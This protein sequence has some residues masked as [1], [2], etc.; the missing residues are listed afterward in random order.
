MNILLTVLIGLNGFILVVWL[1]RLVLLSVVSRILAPLHGTMYPAAA[2]NLPSVSMIVAA[3]DE[4]HNIEACI[5]SLERQTYPTLQIIAVNDRSTDGTREM[6]DRLAKECPRLTVRHVAQLREGWFGKN[7]AMREGVALAKGDWLCF[8]DADCIQLSPRSLE[9]AMRYALEKE[10]DFLSVLPSHEVH[11][12]WERVVQPACSA[13]MILWFSPLVVNNPRRKTAYANGAF[14][15][16]KRSCYEAMGGHEAVKNE[17]NEDMHMARIA[18]DIGRRLIVVN[19]RDLYTV[20]M[21]GTLSQIW[22]GWTRIFCGSFVTPRRLWAAVIVLATFS[23]APWLMLLFAV[24]MDGL[25]PE[26]WDIESLKYGAM[27]SCAAQLVTMGVFYALSR[28]GFLYGL[29][30]PI[31]AFLSMGTLLNAIRCASGRGDIRWR[32]TTYRD[33]AIAPEIGVV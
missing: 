10:T 12:F 1:M 24:L 13:I 16:M 27:A 29:I 5:H 20:R 30:Y 22:R 14:M 31:G 21:Y 19:N 26:R 7:N 11:S 2:A 15:L 3:K 9:I 18:K 25:S 28:V 23:F 8:T 33:G 4:A 17:I 32:G 6:L